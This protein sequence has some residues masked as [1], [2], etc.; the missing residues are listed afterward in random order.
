M[1]GCWRWPRPIPRAPS[2][3]R[4][5]ALP[6]ALNSVRLEGRGRGL[7]R[8]LGGDWLRPRG[9]RGP[10]PG[11]RGPRPGPA[12]SPRRRPFKPPKKTVFAFFFFFFLTVSRPLYRIFFTT[13][14]F[15][16]VF[17]AVCALAVCRGV[18]HLT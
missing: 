3:G 13:P 9:G 2:R 5:R 17:W 14:R 11:A 6:G 18:K 15:H 10:A 8:R 12:R 16:K 1:P 4:A 7:G